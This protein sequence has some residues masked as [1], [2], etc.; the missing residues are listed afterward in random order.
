[1]AHVHLKDVDAA[2]ADEVEARAVSLPDATRR[3][4]FR[5]LGE[6]CAQVKP[7]LD[8]LAAGG[9]RGWLALEQDVMLDSADLAPGEG[10]IHDVRRCI[11]FVRG[12]A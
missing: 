1:V 5:P 7:V 6:G 8:A 3:G 11:E 12:A 10:P 9:Y 4:L 2:L